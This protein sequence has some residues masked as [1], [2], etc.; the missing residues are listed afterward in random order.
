MS[1]TKEAADDAGKDVPAEA[2]RVPV[3]VQLTEF[4]HAYLTARAKAH[5][6]TPERHLETILRAFRAYH[7]RFRHGRDTTSQHV[8]QP[9]GTALR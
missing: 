4:H 1:A 2:A 7:D 6:E 3:T 5:G 9:A 8:G